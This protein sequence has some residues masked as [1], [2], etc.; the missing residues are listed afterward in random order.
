[1]LTALEHCTIRTTKLSETRQFFED[2]L[3]LQQGPRPPLRMPG[4]WLY[5]KEVPVIHLMEIGKHYEQDPFGQILE[6]E[7]GSGALDHIAFRGQDLSALLKKLEQ[8]QIAFRRASLPEIG[9]EQ[10]FVK[11]PNGIILE[12]NFRD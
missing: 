10:V 2:V 8:L 3:G 1:M 6:Q 7:E 4:F 11:D 5:L 9:L 12:L